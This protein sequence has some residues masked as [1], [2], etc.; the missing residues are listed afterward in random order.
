MR[1]QSRVLATTAAATLAIALA[2]CGGDDDEDD[3]AARTDETASDLP[4]ATTTTAPPTPEEL[5]V[6]AYQTSWEVSLQALDPPQELPELFDVMT[7]EALSERLNGIHNRA[8]LGHY[9]QGTVETHPAVVSATASEVLLDD[10]A[11]ENSVE[12]DADGEVVDPAEDVHANYRVTVVLEDDVWKVAD[13]ERRDEACV[14][15]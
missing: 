8:R 14:P 10:C 1:T 2:A 7:G 4:A 11:V 12:Y 6:A 9:I 15:G 5:A 3:D 13:F